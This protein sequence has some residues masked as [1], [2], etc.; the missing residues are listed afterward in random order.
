ML[1]LLD[2]KHAKVDIY[3]S[4]TTKKMS[5]IINK[6]RLKNVVNY[7]YICIYPSAVKSK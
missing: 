4:N 7:K 5:V 3:G 2:N 6:N 1:N